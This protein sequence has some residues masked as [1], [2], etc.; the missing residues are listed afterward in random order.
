MQ[1]PEAA[2]KTASVRFMVTPAKVDEPPGL[3]DTS[4][5]LDASSRSGSRVRFSSRDSAPDTSR[6]EPASASASDTSG[7]T[8]SLDRAPDP[9][10]KTPGSPR[11]PKTGGADVGKARPGKAPAWQPRRFPPP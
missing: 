10:G 2:A 4:P 9:D 3:S 8:S 6:S 1:P 7:L 11:P 5:D